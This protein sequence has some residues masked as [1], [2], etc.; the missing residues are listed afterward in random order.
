MSVEKAKEVYDN[1]LGQLKELAQRPMSIDNWS[2]VC[3][4]MAKGMRIATIAK[5]EDVS[6]LPF[7][8]TG[9]K[10]LRHA[11]KEVSIEQALELMD[12][13]NEFYSLKEQQVIL[14]AFSGFADR[15][16]EWA[17]AMDLHH[18]VYWRMREN[19]RP[20]NRNDEDDYYQ[21]DRPPYY[22]WVL[23]NINKIKEHFKPLPEPFADEANGNP[24]HDRLF[25]YQQTRQLWKFH[26]EFVETL[27]SKVSEVPEENP[28]VGKYLE[29]GAKSVAEIPSALLK[30]KNG[31]ISKELTER[32]LAVRDEDYEG[33]FKRL[34]GNAN[35]YL[36]EQEA[37]VRDAINECLEGI[38]YEDHD[39]VD[40]VNEK[41]DEIDKG[42][43]KHWL[44]DDYCWGPVLAAALR[45]PR[46]TVYYFDWAMHYSDE[47]PNEPGLVYQLRDGTSQQV[48]Y[49]VRR[50][51][52]WDGMDKA[53]WK[54]QNIIDRCKDVAA[55]ISAGA[56]LNQ[57]Y[58]I[59]A[60]WKKCKRGNESLYHSSGDTDGFAAAFCDGLLKMSVIL[61]DIK[62]DPEPKD[63]SDPRYASVEKTMAMCA[64]MNPSITRFQLVC[65]VV[66]DGMEAACNGEPDFSVWEQPWLAAALQL[67]SEDPC[68]GECN[69]IDRQ[70]MFNAIIPAFSKIVALLSLVLRE[71]PDII[72]EELDYFYQ[73]VNEIMHQN[74]RKIPET[75]E[76]GVILTP[77]FVTREGT[78]DSWEFNDVFIRRLASHC[79]AK[80]ALKQF[81]NVALSD[82]DQ[83]MVR[84]ANTDPVDA[85]LRSFSVHI[86][87]QQA[88]DSATSL[89]G[90]LES[91]T[92]EGVRALLSNESI[93]SEI[94]Q[95]FFGTYFRPYTRYTNMV[96]KDQELQFDIPSDIKQLSDLIERFF[97]RISKITGIQQALDQVTVTWKK[98]ST[99]YEFRM[100][101][102]Y[103]RLTTKAQE[104]YAE[105]FVQIAKQLATCSSEGETASMPQTAVQYAQTEMLKAFAAEMTPKFEALKR[106]GENVNRNILRYGGKLI[107]EVK[108]VRKNTQAL[109]QEQGVDEELTAHDN[110]VYKPRYTGVDLEMLETAKDL[111]DNG[112]LNRSSAAQHV[113]S[114]YEGKEHGFSS[115][116]NFKSIFY[117]Y[118][119]NIKKRS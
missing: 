97:L 82:S 10:Y 61:P 57:W 39:V 30:V 37:K 17:E 54:I 15:L 63:K 88:I 77:S 31:M 114:Q 35:S 102:P 109:L 119:K 2:A 49:Q 40:V 48:H 83:D 111:V 101:N 91:A 85:G 29:W 9:L 103:M 42:L 14:D 4:L 105:L 100:K 20:W 90:S 56:L 73:D 74:W 19:T 68:R 1:I 95:P 21:D 96:G 76:E 75:G 92:D 116:K 106:Q 94:L 58:D 22:G 51:K 69:L 72:A 25:A 23:V 44:A 87:F 113:Y 7:Y 33:L 93:M 84:A 55:Q 107:G 118:Y 52:W 46:Y 115:L 98:I 50:S 64:K 67:L 18:G 86:L 112:T 99:L 32:N 36:D 53:E 26:P 28:L 78:N 80:N 71:H 70:N 5:E 6:V 89:I 47:E 27:L 24:F 60:A 11:P 65:G 66:R 104:E 16:E 59:E 79:S 38:V 45:L 13:S 12:D 43:D 110:E 8:R 81:Q 117:R 3:N 41:L 108:Q 62:T 34:N